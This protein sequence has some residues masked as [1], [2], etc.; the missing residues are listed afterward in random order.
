MYENG[1]PGELFL[2]ANKP[3][4]M[5]R[6]LFDALAMSVSIAL[7]HGVP[8]GAIVRQWK[9]MN[10]G[11]GGLTGDEGYPIASSIL[12]YIATWIL[13]RFGDVGGGK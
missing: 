13:M 6:G 1:N 5:I 9:N 10:F 7:Q 8:I 2:T 3:G 12:D 11:P 4:D